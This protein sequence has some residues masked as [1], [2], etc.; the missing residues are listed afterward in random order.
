MTVSRSGINEVS[1]KDFTFIAAFLTSLGVGA[2]LMQ[3]RVT[4]QTS[5]ANTKSW[6]GV[7]VRE[8]NI[9]D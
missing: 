1:S 3:I 5:K 9:A 4:Q 7:R 2:V 6:D 8:E